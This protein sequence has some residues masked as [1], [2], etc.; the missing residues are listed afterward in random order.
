MSEP[1][2]KYNDLIKQDA[3]VSGEDKKHA[4]FMK[5]FMMRHSQVLNNVAELCG[6]LPEHGEFYALWSLRSFNTFTF[7]Q[8]FINQRGAIDDLIIT[9]Y[10]TLS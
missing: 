9:T 7:V 5:R 6:E 1:L 2:F 4:A 3:G 10:N 8:Y